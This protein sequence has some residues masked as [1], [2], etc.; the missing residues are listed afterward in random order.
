MTTAT[1]K[2]VSKDI[3]DSAAWGNMKP[4]DVRFRVVI[5]LP[6][7]EE[8]KGHFIDEVRKTV[9]NLNYMYFFMHLNMLNCSLSWV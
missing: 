1:R 4:S 9:A 2:L 3:K 5:Q 7:K 6:G 8:H